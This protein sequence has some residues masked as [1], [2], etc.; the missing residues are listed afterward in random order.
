[1]L[2][3]AL[4]RLSKTV[5]SPESD[6]SVNWHRQA[7]LATRLHDSYVS[8]VGWCDLKAFSL[9]LPAIPQGTALRYPT[10]LRYGMHSFSRVN[11]YQGPMQIA[12]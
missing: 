10:E 3:P 8:G 9:I 7:S 11:R 1:M 5:V 4:E 12:V 6:Y 2:L